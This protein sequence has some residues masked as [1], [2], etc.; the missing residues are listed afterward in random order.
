MPDAESLPHPELL[1]M[2]FALC[3]QFELAAKKMEKGAEV[4]VSYREGNGKRNSTFTATLQLK[5]DKKAVVTVVAPDGDKPQSICCNACSKAPCAHAF[6]AI[7][8]AMQVSVQ[9]L[10]ELRMR[11]S[12]PKKEAPST[13]FIREI[14]Q[15]LR[16]PLTEQEATYT[17]QLEVLFHRHSDS[18][19]LAAPTL[20]PFLGNAGLPPW[21]LVELW[22]RR[23]E[24]TWEAWLYL[25]AFLRSRALEWP[26]FLAE[27]TT[28]E[29][30]ERLAGDWERQQAL[31]VWEDGLGKLLTEMESSQDRRSVEAR[32]E[33]GTTCARL[34]L[35]RGTDDEWAQPVEQEYDELIS[36]L[37]KGRLDCDAASRLLLEAFSQFSITHARVH[38]GRDETCERLA[39]LLLHPL[40]LEH[41]F[42]ETGSLIE[43]S[44]K[45]LVWRLRR[46]EASAGADADYLLELAFEDGERPGAPLFT[47][48]AELNCYVTP[49]AIYKTA[50][51]L[52]MDVRH[53]IRIP[54]GGLFNNQTVRLLHGLGVD[55]PD[56]IQSRVLM[57]QPE[58]RLRCWL[59]ERA[60]EERLHV[61]ARALLG[62]HGERLYGVS[63]WQTSQQPLENH[64]KILMLD[65]SLMRLVPGLLNNLAAK[66]YQ[67]T[68]DSWGRLIGKRFAE[69][70]SVWMADLPKGIH[71][72]LEGD[73]ASLR[74]ALVSGA[75]RLDV[76][77]SSPDWFDLQVAM[78]LSDTELTPEEVQL[79]LDAKGKFVRLKDKGWRRLEFEIDDAQADQLSELGVNPFEIGGAPQRYHALQL[80]ASPARHF[81]AEESRDTVLRRASEIQTS[82]RP[83]VPAGILA[84]MRGYQVEGFQFLAYL[85][86]NRF[87]GILADDMG[88][89]K[90][91]QTLA[92]LAWLREQPD[93]ENKP[94]LVVCPKSV[95]QNWL[96]EISRFLPSVRATIWRGGNSKQLKQ[97]ISETDILISNYA[98]LR[99]SAELM[100]EV[101]W[102]AIVLDEAQYIKNP[103]SQTAVAASALRG[104]HRLA[105]SGTPI[106]NRLLDLWSIM[107]FSMP[108]L[109]GIRAQFQRQYDSRA[110]GLARKRLAS[111]IRP[112]I[113]RRTKGEVAKDLPERIEEDLVVE[114]EGTQ[115]SLYRAELKRARQA[116][117]KIQSNRQL[118]KERFNV[119]TSLLRLRQICCHPGLVSPEHGHSDSAKMEALLDLLE[120]LIEQGNKVLIFSQFVDMLE[121]IEREIDARDWRSFMLTG[122][123]ENRGELV[124]EFQAHEGA[125]AFLISLRAGGMGLNLTAA[126]Y[127]VLFDPWWNPAVENQAID[128]THRIG[129]TQRV[130]AYRLVTKSTVEEKI[131]QLQR[132]KSVLAGDILG[133]ESFSKALTLDDFQFLLQE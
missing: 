82:V 51:Q 54:R 88:L 118:D 99:L 71:I 65:E 98:Q 129:Q 132:S 58:V 56:E 33:I 44:P 95:V 111:R 50:P 106:E 120:P 26:P 28:V 8:A 91:L 32:L 131:R 35:R 42:T 79:L 36:Y 84:T 100:A 77:E 12:E 48:A 52:R 86:A 87:G 107:H 34:Q 57:L 104:K 7:C 4:A 59:E 94:V 115:A 21:E 119:L 9:K 40:L 15:K 27:I 130:I 103:S 121:R 126:S 24:N 19:M 2:A 10:S 25:A 113:L 127:V 122:E 23:P 20:D 116:L 109:L 68:S 45:K 37:D 70:F 16:R 108:G 73:L 125:A 75:I 67:I 63:G 85:S 49:S 69:E 29:A 117:L 101:S 3:E 55:L 133:E 97:A 76:T 11:S 6:L 41:V 61:S 90:T 5:R 74:N 1:S 31:R 66:E 30:I 64:G 43:R 38:Y 123:T 18:R 102:E 47:A 112:F 46:D 22:P 80:A 89:G 124:D 110:D 72:D 81:L 17:A 114:M 128:R 62:E 105:L 39:R 92:W 78:S 60:G 14:S 96:S 13:P 83:Q 93:F 53:P